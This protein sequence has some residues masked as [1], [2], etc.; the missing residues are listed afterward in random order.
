MIVTRTAG[1]RIASQILQDRGAPPRHAELQAELLIEAELRGHPSH[2]LLRLPR[3]V[4]RI[5]AGVLDP[6]TEGHSVWTHSALLEVDGEQGFGAVI[7]RGALASITERATS[8]GI[9][10]AVIRNNNHIGMLA[11]YAEQI[12]SHGQIL[13]ASTTSEALVHPWGGSRPMVGTNPLAI[14]VPT[15]GDPLVLD[16]ATGVVSMGKINA[17]AAAGRELEPGWAVDGEGQPTIDAEAAKSGAIAPFG[18]AKGYGL[19]MALEAMVA[20]LTGT[21]LG[22]DVV[23][24]LDDDCRSTKGDIF[25]VAEARP[26]AGAHLTD[27]LD[28]VRHSPRSDPATRITVP[29]DR[30]RLRKRAAIVE[31]FRVPDSLWTELTSLASTAPAKEPW[32]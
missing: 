19:G 5:A 22:R 25:I 10:A 23:G 14:G 24:T 12:A 9:A 29:G 15:S 17:Y 16:M 3:L 7:A 28:G 31:G 8:A 21:A 30:S 32:T 26:A 20:A 1:H 6:I 27:Y 11:H 13:I 2:G 4:R 18:G